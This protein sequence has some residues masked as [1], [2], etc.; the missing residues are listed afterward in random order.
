MKRR[1]IMGM[2]LLGLILIMATACGS[3]DKETTSQPPAEGDI[4]VTITADGNI[5]AFS[6]VKLTFG[7]GGK[8]AQVAVKEGDMVA[9][10]DVLATLETDAL[11]LAFSQ[12][13]VAQAEAQVAV[14]LA[15][16]AVNQARVALQ[17]AEYNLNQTHSAYTLKDIKAAE[18]DVAIAHK[19][20]EEALWILSKYDVYNWWD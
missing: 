5:E 16:I 13:K 17:T 12:A 8:V 20:L 14:S 3:D 1:G 10:D 2:L 4:N 6:E 9:K 11:E 19:D 15:E 18:S 7:S